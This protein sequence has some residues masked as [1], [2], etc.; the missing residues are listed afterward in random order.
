MLEVRQANKEYACACCG[1]KIE[2]RAEYVK[3]EI[4]TNSKEWTDSRICTMC[5]EQIL[6][7]IA[8]GQRPFINAP[9]S[10]LI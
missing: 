8:R 10:S 7:Q 4:K 2:H 9:K 1:K 3:V 5:A 6:S